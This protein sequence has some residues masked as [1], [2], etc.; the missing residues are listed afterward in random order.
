MTA[1]E[2][3][4][5]LNRYSPAFR[6]YLNDSFYP[7]QNWT[8]SSVGYTWI[9][10]NIP[11]L[12][13]LIDL[14]YNDR[15]FAVYCILINGNPLYVGQSIRTA[16]R[17]CVHAYNICHSPELFGLSKEDI[18]NNTISVQILEKYIYNKNLRESSELFYIAKLKPILQ[19]SPNSARPRA[20]LPYLRKPSNTVNLLL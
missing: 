6:A 18:V 17:L 9:W 7:A 13:N 19:C 15:L 14:H 5:N 8:L 1:K 12:Q 20:V 2:N 4:T 11:S 10:E 3:S 16:K